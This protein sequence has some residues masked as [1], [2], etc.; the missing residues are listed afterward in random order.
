MSLISTITR[1]ALLSALTAI[2]LCSAALAE[3]DPAGLRIVNLEEAPFLFLHISPVTENTWGPDLLGETLLERKGVF[4]VDT[5]SLGGGCEFDLMAVDILGTEMSIGGLNLCDMAEIRFIVAGIELEYTDG[6]V[7]A[8]HA[9][10][11]FED[12]AIPV[13]DAAL[14]SAPGQDRY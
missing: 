9:R 4:T 12:P 5:A 6:V 14:Q 8:F 11:Q 3:P 7:E 2:G 13:W 1:P 10:E